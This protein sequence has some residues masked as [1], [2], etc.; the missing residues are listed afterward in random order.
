MKR[1]LTTFF[2]VLMGLM[3][4]GVSYADNTG[5]KNPGTATEDAGAGWSNIPP[6]DSVQTSNDTRTLTSTQDTLFLTNFSMG[7]PTGATITAI[8]VS[9]EAQGSASQAARRRLDVHVMKNGRDGVGDHS[10][11]NF[12]L[13]SDGTDEF[14][15]ELDSLWGTTWTVAEANS[16]NFGIS[17]RKN[18]GQAGNISVDH[19][20]ILIHYTPAAGGGKA[21]VIK[22]GIID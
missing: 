13:D 11:F 10:D 12:P 16:T 14:A 17:L 9:G 3:C 4:C 8:I 15:G 21:Q 6:I 18:A 2:M 5:A 20:T 7:V 19:F 22:K 1:I